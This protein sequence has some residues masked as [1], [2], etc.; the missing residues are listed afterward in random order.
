M[1]NVTAQLKP[2]TPSSRQYK[3][4][5]KY[6]PSQKIAAGVK[7]TNDAGNRAALARRPCRRSRP[8]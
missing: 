7:M 5:E 6:E 8:D 4:P 2:A 3:A 1:A